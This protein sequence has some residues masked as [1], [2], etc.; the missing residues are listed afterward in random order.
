MT[1][2]FI[3]DLNC[4]VELNKGLN[5]IYIENS[6]YFRKLFFENKNNLFLTNEKGLCLEESYYIVE[7]PL[8]LEFN[9]KKIIGGVYKILTKDIKETLS[10]DYELMV[11]DVISF[12]NKLLSQ[13]EFNLTMEEE[14]DLS[15]FLQVFNVKVEEV[16][17]SDYVLRLIEYFKLV[18]KLIN[19]NYFLIFNLSNIFDDQELEKISNE[20]ELLDLIVI[21]FSFKQGD[22]AS[23]SYCVLKIDEDLNLM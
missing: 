17:N 22:S 15:K 5:V 2:L 1:E 4:K 20:C 8:S 19:T 18:L 10:K 9:N 7:N 3:K 11:I 21:D 23:K 13:S 12:L 16:E 6:Y 14:V